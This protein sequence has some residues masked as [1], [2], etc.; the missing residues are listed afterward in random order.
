MKVQLD[1]FI[2]VV[3]LKFFIHAEKWESYFINWGLT[4]CKPFWDSMATF[5]E[6]TTPTHELHC[7]RGFEENPKMD[8]WSRIIWIHPIN[9]EK[10]LLC[11]EVFDN[12]WHPASD[13]TGQTE[14]KN[15][16]RL[17]FQAEYRSYVRHCP[18]R[19][20]ITSLSDWVNYTGKRDFIPSLKALFLSMC[21]RW[22]KEET[23]KTIVVHGCS[24]VQ[25]GRRT[26]DYFVQRHRC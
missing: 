21:K 3:T 12:F 11:L 26:L 14:N 10:G 24:V 22:F 18:S 17:S 6:L 15:C 8:L 19:Y 4:N 7:G 9:S 16:G 25:F 13:L 5:I 1:N 23:R 20:S 2:S